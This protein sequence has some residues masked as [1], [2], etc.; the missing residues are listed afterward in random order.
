MQG[1]CHAE[2]IG[3]GLITIADTARSSDLNRVTQRNLMEAC[4][5]RMRKYFRSE[6]GGRNLV[7]SARQI[8]MSRILLLSRLKQCS[9]SLPDFLTLYEQPWAVPCAFSRAVKT[10]AN[11][12]SHRSLGIFSHLLGRASS[13]LREFMVIVIVAGEDWK[14]GGHGWQVGPGH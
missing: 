1:Q 13:V 7:S 3:R 12:A 6:F 11:Q 2:A 4:R 8:R 9:K 10:Q 14:C 5:S